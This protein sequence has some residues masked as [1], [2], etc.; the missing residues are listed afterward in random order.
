MYAAEHFELFY[1]AGAWSWNDAY[2][3]AGD[4]FEDAF[5]TAL[6]LWRDSPTPIALPC[7]L[8]QLT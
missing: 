7:L 2:L 8:R 5:I 3:A 6:V 4:R 1:N